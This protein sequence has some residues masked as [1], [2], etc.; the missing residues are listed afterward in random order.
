[1]DKWYIIFASNI[2]DIGGA[3][4]Y[5]DQKAAFLRKIGWR[6]FL[7]STRHGESI[8]LKALKQFQGTVIPH[9]KYRPYLF[10]ESVQNR[11]INQIL[12]QIGLNRQIGGTERVVLESHTPSTALWA[13]LVA[14]RLNCKSFVYLLSE[15]FGR[16]SASVMRFL[17]FK[18]QR[19]E[20]AGIDPKSLGL[21]FRGYKPLKDNENY[22]LRAGSL[23]G[24]VTDYINPIVDNLERRDINIGCISRLDKP[25]VRAVL[26]EV[27]LFANR[28]RNQTVQLVLVGDSQSDRR[29]REIMKKIKEAENLSLVMTGSLFPLPRSLFEKLDIFIG[30]AGCAYICANEGALTISIDALQHT[31]IGFL[32]VD[33]KEF[34]YS[35]NSLSKKSL[36]GMLEYVFTRRDL[37]TTLK[38]GIEKVSSST[39]DE[40]FDCHLRFIRSSSSSSDFYDVSKMTLEMREKILRVILACTGLFYGDRLVKKYIFLRDSAAA[41]LK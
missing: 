40:E 8:V 12:S 24:N 25:Y 3:Q 16:G 2:Y 6:F 29:K 39:C 4:L 30:S 15:S 21:L 31:P 13:E 37:A 27:V 32:G 26:D 1:M 23:D 38:R 19:R 41:I 11:I 28:V 18:H 9:L 35:K 14:R 17:D 36:S 7:F 34:L 33:T 10:S 22:S 20:I 5:C